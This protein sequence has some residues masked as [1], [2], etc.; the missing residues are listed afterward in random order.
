MAITHKLAFALIA[1]AAAAA[2][3]L[4]QGRAPFT[5]VETGR[6]YGS[7]ADA[8]AAIGDGR[9]TIRIAPGRYRDCAVQEAGQVAYV[10]QTPGTAIFDGGMCEDKATLVLR[11][12]SARVEGLVFTHMEVDDGNGAGIRIEH[13]DLSV[14][15]VL[16]IDGQC[17][18]LSATDPDSSITIDH[19]TFSGLGRDPDGDGSHSL[20][21]GHYGSLTVTNSRFERGTG[22]HYLKSRAPRIEVLGSSFDDSRGSHT[23]YLI[24]LPNGA[25]GRIAGNVF[26]NGTG[27]DN[28]MTMIAVGAE[29]HEHSSTGLVIEDN[30]V[31]VAPGFRWHTAFVGNWSGD[32]LAVGENRLSGNIAL[33]E[34][35]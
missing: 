21:I 18:I 1:A 12:T 11:G 22:G 26:V 25:V 19:S 15:Q 2:P 30:D 7:L 20:Y 34:R 6:H 33:L 14:S 8:V 4:A 16:F 10:A 13:G 9:G 24:D 32:R 17:G 5:V 27:K 35:R 29:E 31:S 3:L 23:N 28:Y